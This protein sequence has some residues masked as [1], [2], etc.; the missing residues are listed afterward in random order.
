MFFRLVAAMVTADAI[1]R[2][3]KD[4]RRALSEERAAVARQTTAPSALGTG[5]GEVDASAWRA[6]PERPLR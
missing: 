2:R 6:A 3:I 1:D 5:R 4:Q